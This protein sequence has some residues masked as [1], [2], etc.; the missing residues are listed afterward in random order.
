MNT[1]LLNKLVAHGRRRRDAWAQLSRSCDQ[2]D[3][4]KIRAIVDEV[5]AESSTVPPKLV[6]ECQSPL[7]AV[8]VAGTFNTNLGIKNWDRIFVGST[9]SPE[10]RNA[11][12][13]VMHG[14]RVNV[15]QV[16]REHVCHMHN[17]VSIP[18][19][20]VV[21]R[22][23][24][25]NYF[26][27]ASA[28][29]Q[30][31]EAVWGVRDVRW[32]M[33]GS[34][35]PG[36]N[37]VWPLRHRAMA[38]SVVER[39]TETRMMGLWD[40]QL[41]ITTGLIRNATELHWAAYGDCMN[42]YVTIAGMQSVT[43][44]IQLAKECGWWIPYRDMCVVT[45]RPE[46]MLFDENGR[47]HSSDGPAILYRD[48]WD[49]HMW[50]GTTFPRMWLDGKTLKPPAALN[51]RNIELRRVA[52]EILGWDRILGE[53]GATIVHKDPNPQIGTLVRV[54]MPPTG[55]TV[56]WRNQDEA[57]QFLRVKCGTGRMF[58]IPV[59]LDVRTARE[60]NAWTYGVAANEYDPEVRT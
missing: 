34:N 27:S 19:V 17:S 24:V 33:R 54:I 35:T 3:M 15:D 60:A 47:L 58:A 45:N 48:G 50:H 20:R 13:S 8:I 40:E 32:G 6:V 42:K 39:V 53:L 29:M 26:R 55:P 16:V 11:A 14:I 30:L 38:E 41:S 1:E 52:C 22:K 21:V 5:Y 4:P 10:A 12:P 28:Q 46:R 43:P 2:I 57:R 23:Y 51:Q 7:A 56:R 36:I 9:A 49:I 31:R 37:A 59:P 18:H 44:H 25:T